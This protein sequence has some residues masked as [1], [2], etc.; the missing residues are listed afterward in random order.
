[1]D[2]TREIEAL[3]QELYE[4]RMVEGRE[5]D[6]LQDWLEAEEIV[7]AIHRRS[8]SRLLPGGDLFRLAV[9]N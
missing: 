8:P 1:M 2:T 5:P 3:A 4:H 9:D 6:A 7:H